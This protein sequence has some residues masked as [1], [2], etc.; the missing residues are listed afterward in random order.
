MKPDSAHLSVITPT[1]GAR[2]RCNTEKRVKCSGLFH[3]LGKL[4]DE[5]KLT[6]IEAKAGSSKVTC[7]HFLLDGQLN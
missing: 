3:E 4:G 5:N 1:P 6:K 7:F 2:S